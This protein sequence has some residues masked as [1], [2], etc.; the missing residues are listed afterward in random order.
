MEP[1]NLKQGEIV[2]LNA[3][4][5]NPA[6]AFCLMIVTEPKP[7]GAQG[8]VQSLGTREAM[9]GQAYYR[10]PWDEMSPTGGFAPWIDPDNL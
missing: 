10:A 8:F 2:Q 4:T 9:G 6:F 1:K 7:W 3:D 5:K